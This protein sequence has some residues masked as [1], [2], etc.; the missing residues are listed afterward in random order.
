MMTKMTSFLTFFIL[1]LGSP[2]FAQ[3]ENS[4]G[5]KMIIIKIAPGKIIAPEL[6]LSLSVERR[7][8]EK[9]SYQLQADYIFS[10]WYADNS[11]DDNEN[12][13]FKGFRFIPEWRYYV[14]DNRN[15][16]A[17]VGLQVMGKYTQDSYEKFSLTSNGSGQTFNQLTKF[18]TDKFVFATHFLFGYLFML[19]RE[20]RISLDYNF[21]L[22]IRYKSIS[23]NEESKFKDNFGYSAEGTYN[24]P[25]ATC[26]LKLG[27]NV[28]R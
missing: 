21:G 17:Y 1:L 6:N 10:R 23:S 8:D 16:N 13:K 5:K 18:Q 3:Y 2:I 14:N 27:Y 9:L 15:A 11:F 22:G 24:L 28:F 4:N 26:N 7:I 20:N 25:S 19:D 12:A